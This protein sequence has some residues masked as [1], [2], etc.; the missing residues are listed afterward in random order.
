MSERHCHESDTHGG[1]VVAAFA[2]LIGCAF[3]GGMAGLVFWLA[4]NG[5]AR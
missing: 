2:F 5:G 3:L 4:L 1:M